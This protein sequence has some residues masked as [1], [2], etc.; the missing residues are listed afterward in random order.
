MTLEDYVRDHQEAVSAAFKAEG[1]REA[2][3]YTRNRGLAVWLRKNSRTS[4]HVE[5]TGDAHQF[6]KGLGAVGIHKVLDR[7]REEAAK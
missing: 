3:V 2:K 4:G 1:Y 7:L 5:L 6:P